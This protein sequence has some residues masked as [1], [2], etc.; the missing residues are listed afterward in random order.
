MS[1]TEKVKTLPEKPGVYIM[2][3]VDGKIIYIGKAVNLR[4]RVRSYFQNS[5]NHSPKVRAMVA[6]IDDFE[7]I[8]TD[9]ELEALILE[10]TLIKRHKPKYNI[11][12][13]DDKN[14]PYLKVTWQDEFP[15][16][17]VTRRFVKDGGRYFGPYSSAGDVHQTLALLKKIFPLRDCKDVNLAGKKRPCLNYYIK[18][19]LAPCQGKIS[20]AE[21]REMIKEICL[22]L[23][24]KGEKVLSTLREKMEKAS[25]EMEFEKAAEYRDQI[26]AVERIV[27]KQKVVSSAMQDQDVIAFAQGEGTCVQVFFIRGGKLIGREHFWLD[28]T[29][30]MEREEIM[31]AF[32]KQFYSQAT[33]IP[34]EILL[35]HELDEH[36]II[37]N[38]LTAKRGAKVYLRVPRKGEKKKLVEMV[39]ENASYL[40][41]QVGAR[42]CKEQE[43]SNGAVEEL[44]KA[45]GLKPPPYRIE[46]YD[47]SNI[48]GSESVG[49]MVVFEGGKPANSQYRR[50]KIKTV[51]GPNDFASMQEVLWRRFRRGLQEK[52]VVL[53]EGGEPKFSHLPDLIVIDGGKG[54]L[55]AACE[56]LR[57][58]HLQI[59]VVGLA[60]EFEHI[61][62]PG[63]SEPIVLPPNSQ[64]L[65]LM[66][67]IRDEAHRFA[68]TY[69]RLLRRK[70][71][72][73][74][75]L[76]TIPGVGPQR[77]NALLK[78]FGSLKKIREADAEEIARVPGINRKVA[79]E[80][81]KVLQNMDEN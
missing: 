30:G 35:Q 79:E 55:S 77:R 75:Q 33:F 22:F 58:L 42:I 50:F 46:C 45:L 24:G 19:C 20:S 16:L 28:N 23:E 63:S 4:N 78:H 64:A 17:V 13:K 25:Q 49:S 81:I 38:W 41:E 73:Q 66:Q 34:R 56:V 44:A 2:K 39:A 69:H 60:K 71:T 52:E 18:R 47:I 1:L 21:Y 62:K 26:N 27:E 7:Y 14:Y 10:C 68:I 54:Q 53:Q 11:S 40:L 8:I 31:T 36:K 5:A 59:P 12:L 51:K 9:S 74:S 37:S 3:D 70:R 48:Q 32:V 72:L 76:D 29:S 15:R 67:R 61:F 57:D 43:M 65:Y 6:N 80:I